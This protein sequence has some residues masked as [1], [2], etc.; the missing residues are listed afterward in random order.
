MSNEK[1]SDPL[2]K[3]EE[4]LRRRA[5]VEQALAGLRPEPDILPPDTQ[6]RPEKPRLYLVDPGRDSQA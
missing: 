4:T 1:H 5:W 2:I 3:N 6:E